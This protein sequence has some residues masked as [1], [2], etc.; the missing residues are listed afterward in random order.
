MIGGLAA[1]LTFA[2]GLVV[3]EP[4]NIIYHYSFLTYMVAHCSSQRYLWRRLEME[5][6]RSLCLLESLHQYL[7][8]YVRSQILSFGMPGIQLHSF[9]LHIIVMCTHSSF[10][11]SLSFLNLLCSHPR[12]PDIL[13]LVQPSLHRTSSSTPFFIAHDPTPDD[14]Q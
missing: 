12:L 10:A 14:L 3:T 2:T 7:H 5:G 4:L 1:H 6:R 9:F 11:W 13:P 8:V